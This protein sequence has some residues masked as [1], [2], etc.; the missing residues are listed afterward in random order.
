MHCAASYERDDRDVAVLFG[1]S[2]TGR[3]MSI[4]HTRAMLRAALAGK[5]D[6][7]EM[8]EDPVFRLGIKD[9]W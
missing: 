1:L 3:R 8:R 7:V 5:L 4:D 6:D 9:A 2:G